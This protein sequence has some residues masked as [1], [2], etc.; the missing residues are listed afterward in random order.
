[1]TQQHFVVFRSLTSLLFLYAG[2]KHLL[3]P[4][5][6]LN[7]IS[8]ST[9]YS[10]IE[11]ESFFK[12]SIYASGLIMVVASLLLLAGYQQRKAALLLLLVLVPITLTVQ[13]EN[14]NDLGPFFKNVAISGSLLLIIKNKKH[15]QTK[16]VLPVHPTYI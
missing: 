9:A 11:N 16:P 15:E 1:M 10:F 2:S 8:Q 7:R 12:F 4:D 5:K 3:H 13:L 6:I 14:L